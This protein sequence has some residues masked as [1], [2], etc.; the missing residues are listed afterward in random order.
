[1]PVVYMLGSCPAI[2]LTVPTLRAHTPRKR[3]ERSGHARVSKRVVQQ[4]CTRDRWRAVATFQVAAVL[5]HFASRSDAPVFFFHFSLSPSCSSLFFLF[6]THP[7]SSFLFSPSPF[8]CPF[9]SPLLYVLSVCI[10][11]CMCVRIW[12]LFSRMLTTIRYM[13]VGQ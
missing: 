12:P 2:L 4:R 1:V 13:Y 3:A 9:F 11:V 8:F 5:T 10:F 6:P 7:F